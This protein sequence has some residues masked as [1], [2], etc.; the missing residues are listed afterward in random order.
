MK[1]ERSKTASHSIDRRGGLYQKGTQGDEKIKKKEAKQK[2]QKSTL[3]RFTQPAL[4]PR[5][6]KRRPRQTSE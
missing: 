3:Y 4:L 2:K 5:T 6:L 1:D